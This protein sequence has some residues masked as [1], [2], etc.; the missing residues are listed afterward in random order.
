MDISVGVAT[1]YVMENHVWNV[2]GEI[3]NF[4]SLFKPQIHYTFLYFLLCRKVLLQQGYQ[5]KILH[6]YT[7]MESV[8]GVK[9][10]AMESALCYGKQRIRTDK[11]ILTHKN[12]IAHQLLS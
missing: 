4:R 8:L 10:E 6:L 2:E 1:F 5:N 12:K 7:G 9:F 11:L 3:T